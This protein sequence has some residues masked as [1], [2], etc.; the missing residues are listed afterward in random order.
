MK[1]KLIFLVAF[2]CLCISCSSSKKT[3][4]TISQIENL[5][6]L[7][8]SKKFEI[9]S[10]W[11]YPMVTNSISQIA[12]SGLLQPGSSANAINL[13]GN[14]NYF[15]ID[16]DS[17]SMYL[18][19]FGERR[20]STTYNSQD[21]AIQFNGQPSDLKIQKNDSKQVYEIRFS[22]KTNNDNHDVFITLAPNLTG[23][24]AIN[25]TF[26]TAINYKG[27]IIALSDKK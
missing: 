12:N 3:A 21:V 10:D 23:T 8:H 24:I 25:S 11:A 15:K 26:R 27:A 16:Q 4:Y 6:Q 1:I 9:Q 18:P 14:A 5:D 7:I 19:F 13:I 20:L 17:I 22:A 2:S